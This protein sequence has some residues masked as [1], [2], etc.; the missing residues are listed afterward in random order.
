M[1]RRVVANIV[2]AHRP[3]A[4][5]RIALITLRTL[6]VGSALTA[7]AC[8]VINRQSQSHAAAGD[9]GM[10]GPE[11]PPAQAKPVWA[12]SSKSLDALVRAEDVA[13][14]GPAYLKIHPT[15]VPEQEPSRTFMAGTKSAAVVSPL[16]VSHA[17][18]QRP[19]LEGSAKEKVARLMSRGV[20]FYDRGLYKDAESEFLS[21]LEFDPDNAAAKSCLE[22]CRKVAAPAPAATAPTPPV[23]PSPI[24]P[25]RERFAPSS[26][27]AR[28]IRPDDVQRFQQS[29]NPPPNAAASQQSAPRQQ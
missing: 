28:M 5:N 19:Q 12:S 24:T 21:V 4:M 27:S 25:N 14:G 29:A 10:P 9:R 17:R 15:G 18:E 16:D 20:A 26:K 6:A 7:L 23:A 8:Q 1:R 11:A 13:A 22:R 2:H 3:T